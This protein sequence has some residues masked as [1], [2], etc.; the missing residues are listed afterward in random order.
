MSDVVDREDSARLRLRQ[1]LH[2]APLFADLDTESMMAIERELTPLV[3]PGGAALFHQGEPA[4][5]VYVVASGCLGVFRHDD[6]AS[7]EGPELIAE[8]TPGNIVGEMSLLSRGVRTRDVAALRDSEVWRLGRDSFEGLTTHHPEVL[9]ALMRNVAARTATPTTVRRRQPRTFAVLPTGPDVA[10]ARFAVLLAAALGRIGNQVQMLGSDSANEEPEWFA[11]CELANSFVLYRADATLTPWTQLCLRQADC[12]IVV[13]NGDNDLPTRLPFEVEEARP[14]AIF[15]RR[16]E[17]VLLHDG[18]DPRPGSTAGLLAEGLYGQH[19]HVRLDMQADF[20][21]LARLVTGHA[22]GIVMAG[23]GARAFT[24]VGVI[25]ALR[26]SGVP[27]DQ[28]AGT[29]MGAIVAAGVASRWT[30]E[31]L[32]TRFHRAFVE[33]NPLSDYTLPV[34]SLFRGRRVTRLLRLAFGEKDIEDLIMPYFCMTANLTT[35]NADVH[36]TGRLWHWLRA[37]V[38]IPGV[39]PPFNEGGQVHVDG[40]VI[41]NFPVRIMQRLGRGITIGVDIDTGGAMSAGES[42]ED[43]WSAREFVSRL[44]WRRQETLPIPSIVRILLRSALVASNARALK[45]RSYCDL[46][47]VPPMQS[48]DLL[49]WTSFHAAIE[50]GYRATME[51]LEKARSLPVGARLFVA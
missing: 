43:T 47:I 36:R 48:Y 13:R 3:L 42:V 39:L 23:G 7:P 26:A 45:D 49:D 50:I 32:S 9:P 20:D 29:S 12:V 51:A 24:H 5:A 40:G 4:D 17:L 27:I 1:A 31:E 15:Q 25:K 44:V 46:L 18:H 14:G 19:H 22:V 34:V 8:I 33:A 37:S 6:K 2:R 35:S 10:S 38:A 30:D 11:H 28:A 41:N 16:R 21:R